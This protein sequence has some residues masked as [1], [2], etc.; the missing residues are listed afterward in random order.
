MLLLF[1]QELDALVREVSKYTI[2]LC[3]IVNNIK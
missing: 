1:L 2:N 3:L